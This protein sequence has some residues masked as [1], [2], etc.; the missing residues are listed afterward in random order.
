MADSLG[1]RMKKMYEDRYRISLTRRVPV[2]LRIDGR[3]FHTLTRGLNKPFDAK[4]IHSMV[5]AATKVVEDVQGAKVAY[6]Q[7]DEISILLTDYDTIYTEAYF[8]YNLQ[9]IVSNVASLATIHFNDYF[10]ERVRPEAVATFDCRAFNVPESDVA[11][12]F[13]WRWRDWERNSIQMLARSLYEQSRLHGKKRADLHEMCFQRGVN[14]ADLDSRFKNG[15]LLV[16]EGSRWF[17]KTDF[18]LAPGE[19][20]EWWTIDEIARG[21]SCEE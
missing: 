10:R 20:S 21:V 12:Y 2:V 19:G 3:A 9:K 15:T 18:S 7:S 14:W 4:F 5:Y 1:D 6:V 11:N 8:D 17:E 13:L 16:R